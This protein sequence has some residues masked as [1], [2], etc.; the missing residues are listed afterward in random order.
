L[1]PR[2][3]IDVILFFFSQVQ[4][5]CYHIDSLGPRGNHAYSAIV[6]LKF[7]KVEF[8]FHPSEKV[9]HSENLATLSA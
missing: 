1:R 4:R 2:D 6:L 9:V 5:H 3:I 8:L 7:V